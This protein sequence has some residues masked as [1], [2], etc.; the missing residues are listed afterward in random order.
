MAGMFD[1]IPTLDEAIAAFTQPVDDKGNTV[2]GNAVKANVINPVMQAAIPTITQKSLQA[3]AMEDAKAIQAGASLPQRIGRAATAV[4]GIAFDAAADLLRM[5][6]PGRVLEAG[7]NTL[8]PVVADVGAGL[9]GDVRPAYIRDLPKIDPTALEGVE[10]GTQSALAIPAKVN[11]KEADNF[12]ALVNMFGGMTRR[13]T[14]ALMKV[15]SPPPVAKQTS[16]KDV[17]GMKYIASIENERA[18]IMNNPKATEKQKMDAE[19]AFR[20]ALQKFFAAGGL[21]PGMVVDNAE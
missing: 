7:I 17:G 15:L 11:A 4:P 3:A 14:D 8:A 18:A 13:D 2:V 21:I 9:R 10:R 19:V 12:A 16:A 1:F 5:S 20:T 6:P